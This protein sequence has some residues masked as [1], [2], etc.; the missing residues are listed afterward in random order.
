[1]R[2]IVGTLLIVVAVCLLGNAFLVYSAWASG[3]AQR[4]EIAFA[5]DHDQAQLDNDYVQ[6]Q[7]DEL[8]QR[9]D[10]RQHL[11]NNGVAVM[12]DQTLL[13]SH[14][15]LARMSRDVARGATPLDETSQWAKVG[16][17]VLALILAAV[18]FA[19]PRQPAPAA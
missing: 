3:A 6:L 16:G 1:M 4:I 13:T 10:E 7:N 14:R 9:I 2:Q 17:A 18:A 12:R 19:W 8:Q 15:M 11:K 5:A